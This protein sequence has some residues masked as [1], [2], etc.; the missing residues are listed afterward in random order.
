MESMPRGNSLW[1]VL[2]LKKMSD[3]VPGHRRAPS[4]QSVAYELRHNRSRQGRTVRQRTS[5][6]KRIPIVVWRSGAGAPHILLTAAWTGG[7]MKLLKNITQPKGRHNLP[8]RSLL[9]VPSQP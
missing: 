3:G 2:E 4:N 7:T 6:L 1:Y 9:N 8:R 5:G